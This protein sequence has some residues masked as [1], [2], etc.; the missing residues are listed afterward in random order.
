LKGRET[1][2]KKFL[3]KLVKGKINVKIVA[4]IERE[5]K[6]KLGILALKKNFRVLTEKIREISVKIDI[7]N[8]RV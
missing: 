6:R 4:K 8:Q 7:K 3:P 2:W 1:N 5:I